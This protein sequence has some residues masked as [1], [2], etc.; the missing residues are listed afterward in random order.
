MTQC[1]CAPTQTNIVERKSR[2]MKRLPY[3]KSLK[4]LRILNKPVQVADISAELDSDAY[5][6]TWLL[7]AEKI[8]A[9]RLRRFRQQL[10]S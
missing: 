2:P 4:R 9:K 5:T 1:R 6:D 7:Q 8:Q 10:A 3:I